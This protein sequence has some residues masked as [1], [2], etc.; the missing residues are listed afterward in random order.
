MAIL[1]IS[2][3]TFLVFVSLSGCQLTYYLKSAYYQTQILHKRVPLAQALKDP[4]TPESIKNKLTLALRAKNF[5]EKELGLTPTKNYTTY[6]DLKRPYVS[7]IV[8]ASPTFA[9]KHHLWHF[10]FV[11]DLPYKGFFSEREAIEEAAAFPNN[12]FD[13][14]IRGVTAYSTLGWFEDPLLNTMMNYSDHDLVNLI[15]H[16]TTHSTLYIKSQADFNE[17]LAT[18][19]G[20]LGTH[21]YYLKEEGN[22]SFTLQTIEKEQHDEQIF[23]H[24]LTQEMDLLEEWYLKENQEKSLQKKENRLE[25]IKF[26]FKSQ[27]VPQLQ[28]RSYTYFDHQKLNNAFLLSL[29]T[30][31]YDLSIF[32]Q[33][34]EK[35]QKDFPRFIKLCKSLEKEKDPKGY[36]ENWLKKS[37]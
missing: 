19:V 26:R 2:I 24:F 25:E 3:S 20:N 28:T 15:I 6:V 13:T 21:L 37:L 32:Q 31:V 11:G 35:L 1:R 12:Q 33:V 4:Q 14:Y 9:L 17:Q 34:F 18:F 7:W 22:N 27:I 16:E 30:Y 10:P 23:S 36:L 5:A 29:K 8:H